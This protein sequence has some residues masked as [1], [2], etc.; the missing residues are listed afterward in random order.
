MAELDDD[1]GSL[2]E[3]LTTDRSGWIR[4]LALT[5]DFARDLEDPAA[6]S[7]SS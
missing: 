5:D 6:V 7:G 1:I 2:R 3:R 4:A